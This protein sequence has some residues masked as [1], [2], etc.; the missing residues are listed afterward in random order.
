MREV[1]FQQ[2]LETLDRGEPLAYPTE[3]FYGLGVD[4][5]RE[6]ALKKLFALKGRDSEKTVSVLVSSLEEL[7]SLVSELSVKSLKII[8]SFLPGPLTLVLPA[9]AGLSPRLLSER[10][11][12]GIRWSSHPL[13]QRL[14][15][16]FGAPITTTSANLSGKPA[17]SGPAEL[18]EYFGG[19]SDLA[20]L[21][22]GKLPASKG[23]TVV[24]VENESLKLIR[25]GEIAFAEILAQ[26]EL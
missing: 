5:R 3:T 4:I 8:S 6:A 2:A 19:S 26:E 1:D 24:K 16:E 14:V 7:K 17:A 12:V 11:Y 10:A 21:N 13:A 15:Q 20:W 25:E 9:R 22:G 23:S 18:E